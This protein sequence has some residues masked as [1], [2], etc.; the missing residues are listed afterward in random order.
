MKPRISAPT[1]AASASGPMEPWVGWLAF[2]SRTS[3][4]SGLPSRWIWSKVRGL[5]GPLLSSSLH[6]ARP[7]PSATTRSGPRTVRCMWISMGVCSGRSQRLMV[8]QM[9]SFPGAP[10]SII[11]LG[12]STT[13]ESTLKPA[14]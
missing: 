13:I 4:I 5:P 8:P 10:F 11:E 12:S 14:T 9:P 2:E 6:P 3:L 1:V 7:K